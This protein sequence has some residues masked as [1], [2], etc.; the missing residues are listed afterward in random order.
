MTISRLGHQTQC[1]SSPKLNSFSH[2]ALWS[3]DI[4]RITALGDCHMR[5][6]IQPYCVGCVG[7]VERRPLGRARNPLRVYGVQSRSGGGGGRKTGSRF[8]PSLY[9]NLWKAIT[10]PP[11]K[12]SLCSEHSASH[13]KRQALEPEMVFHASKSRTW[14]ISMFPPIHTS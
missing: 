10:C 3:I 12:T 11:G 5:F 4:S 13:V 14:I 7:L 1:Q 2:W 9:C 6:L 8:I